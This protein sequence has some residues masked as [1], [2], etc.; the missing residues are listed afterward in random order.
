MFAYENQVTRFIMEKFADYGIEKEVSTGLYSI[1]IFAPN[2][3]LCIEIDGTSHYYGV[4]DME[5]RKSMFKY[6]LLEKAGFD[7]M[8]LPY[9]K[10][11]TKDHNEGH[12]GFALRR[13]LI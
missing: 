10:Y 9:Y 2:E 7:I 6:R 4:T 5:L 13:D 3:K 8:R 1:D 11:A 12:G